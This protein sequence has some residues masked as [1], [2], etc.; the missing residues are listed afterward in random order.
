MEEILDT[1]EAINK[2]M[3]IPE[4]SLLPAFQVIQQ[5]KSLPDFLMLPVL[6]SSITP[7]SPTSALVQGLDMDIIHAIKAFVS[8]TNEVW[9]KSQSASNAVIYACQNWVTHLSR[10]PNPWNNLNMLNLKHVFKVFCDVHLLSWLEMQW[11]FGGLQSCL[12]VLSDGQELGLFQ[13]E[14]IVGDLR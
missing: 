10:A 8:F 5:F 9:E 7:Q 13:N 2:F 3:I 1:V 11:C 12:V 4:S 14:G 6:L